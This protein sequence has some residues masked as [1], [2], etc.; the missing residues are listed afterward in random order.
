MPK[1]AASL[2]LCVAQEARRDW[3]FAFERYSSSSGNLF[4][5]NLFCFF[6]KC[7]IKNVFQIKFKFFIVKVGYLGEEKIMIPREKPLV[8]L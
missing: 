1:I 6:F 8:C 3:Y 7:N 4:P 2:I 5:L